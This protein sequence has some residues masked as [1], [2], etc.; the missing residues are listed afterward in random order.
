LQVAS[1]S[2]NAET[3]EPLVRTAT[4]KRPFKLGLRCLPKGQGR[5]QAG[6]PI[7]GRANSVTAGIVRVRAQLYQATSFESLQCPHDAGAL[8]GQRTAKVADLRLPH[9]VKMGQYGKLRACLIGNSCLDRTQSSTIPI[10]SYEQYSY[11]PFSLG[12]D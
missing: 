6:M 11:N 2:A 9:F 4:A 5:Q 8:S 3:A 1:I 10:K 7:Q 12:L